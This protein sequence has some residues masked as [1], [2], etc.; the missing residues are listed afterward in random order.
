MC[1]SLLLSIIF[2]SASRLPSVDGDNS[3]WGTILNE[4]LSKIA[5]SNA[6]E[7]NQTMVNG[8]NIYSSSINSTH[9]LDGTINA[10]DLGTNSVSDDE[11][12]FEGNDVE[13]DVEIIPQ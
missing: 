2:V 12:T 6:T 5:G 8:T 13:K 10:D 11:S 1:I 4:Y 9:L 3:T 7:L